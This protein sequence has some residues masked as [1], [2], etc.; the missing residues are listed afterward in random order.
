MEYIKEDA[1]KDIENIVKILDKFKSKDFIFNIKLTGSIIR[2]TN[3]DTSDIDINII[4]NTNI[5]NK[6]LF[7][8]NNVL[9]KNTNKEY[10][11]PNNE[12]IIFDFKSFIKKYFKFRNELLQYLINVTI[13]EIKNKKKVFKIIYNKQEYDIAICID[14]HFYAKERIYIGTCLIH[15]IDNKLQ[16]KFLDFMANK[17]ILKNKNTN[18]NFIKI[19]KFFKIVKKNNNLSISSYSLENLIYQVPDHY[20]KDITLKNIKNISIYL[21]SIIN[22]DYDNLLTIDGIMNLNIFL[23]KYKTMILLKNVIKLNTKSKL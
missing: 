10:I 15:K 8:E 13:F 14:Y 16:L 21:M 7:S 4:L 20:F 19:I 9:L 22:K 17:V 23:D 11:I 12:K 1:K 2:S 5:T 6:L 18:G 3:I